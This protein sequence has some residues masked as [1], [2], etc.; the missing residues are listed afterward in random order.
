MVVP[1]SMASAYMDQSHFDV[2]DENGRTT[3][4][5]VRAKM[6]LVSG[7]QKTLGILRGQGDQ[8]ATGGLGIEQ[9]QQSASSSGAG[10]RK[11][12]QVVITVAVTAGR[13]HAVSSQFRQTGHQRYIGK[14]QSEGHPGTAGHLAAVADQAE[15][16][17]I[18]GG[19]GVTLDASVRRPHG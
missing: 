17:H 1:R 13:H 14:I 18:G 11:N 4:P 8:Q 12:W 10:S 15:A 6:P 2:I 9:R 19:A 7:S 5:T 3:E 16:G